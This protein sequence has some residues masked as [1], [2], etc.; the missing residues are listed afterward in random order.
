MLHNSRTLAF[1]VLTA[2]GSVIAAQGQ[3]FD[4]DGL[5]GSA[6]RQ[7]A[8]AGEKE[9][10]ITTLDTDGV[11]LAAI[12]G[13]HEMVKEQQER[14]AALELKLAELMAQDERKE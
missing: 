11:A 14:I 3:Q 13:L 1:G 9:T 5:A 12:Q 8:D 2:L 7:I 6:G 10:M 4:T